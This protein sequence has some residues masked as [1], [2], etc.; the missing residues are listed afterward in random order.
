MTKLLLSFLVLV[1][2]TAHAQKTAVYVPFLIENAHWNTTSWAK[3]EPTIYTQTIISN[4]D[5]VIGTHTYKKMYSRSLKQASV[6]AGVRIADKPDEC[7]KAFREDTANMRVYIYEY[8]HLRERL[9]F[10]FNKNVGDS[11]FFDL[12]NLVVG[13]K[14][15]KIDTV[16]IAGRYRT[17]FTL[18]IASQGHHIPSV[19]VTGIGGMTTGLDMWRFATGGGGGAFQCYGETAGTT[20]SYTD[21]SCPYIFRNTTPAGITSA[22]TNNG[23]NIY[24]NPFNDFI[25]IDANAASIR[26]LDMTGR[27]IIQQDLRNKRVNTQNIPQGIYQLVLYDANGNILERKKVVKE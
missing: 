21:S 26:L 1:A 20:G 18:S 11:M 17:R 15:N 27:T 13:G 9:M 24:P 7:I 14:V 22:I 5:T 19:V 3:Y 23:V 16:F 6:A 2:S 12:L 10:D 25:D 8:W 4:E